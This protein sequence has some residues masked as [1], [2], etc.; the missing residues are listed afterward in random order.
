MILPKPTIRV[1]LCSRINL[2][3]SNKSIKALNCLYLTLFSFY[4]CQVALSDPD[5]GL[6]YLMRIQ[7]LE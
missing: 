1:F 5:R 4:V 7:I 3:P 2:E 6:A